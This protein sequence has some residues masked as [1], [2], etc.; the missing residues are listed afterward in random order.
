MKS[1]IAFFA[2]FACLAFAAQAAN[3]NRTS[4]LINDGIDPAPGPATVLDGVPLMEGLQLPPHDKNEL[5][6]LPDFGAD[7][8][9]VVAI[10]IADV[11]DVYNYYKTALPPLGWQAVSGRAYMRGNEILHVDVTVEGK[12]T[13]VTFVETAK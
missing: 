7:P 3:I 9:T 1:S 6:I 2:L 13:T 10:G 4:S 8:G 12:I 5:N 11:D